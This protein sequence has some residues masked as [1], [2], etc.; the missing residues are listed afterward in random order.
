VDN[1]SDYF[2]INPI[3]LRDKVYAYKTKDDKYKIKFSGFKS[4][5]VTDKLYDDMYR[6]L[7]NEKDNI[8]MSSEYIRK[9]LNNFSIEHRVEQRTFIFNYDKRER[10]IKDGV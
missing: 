2:M 1:D 7:N 10:I 3:F 8:T 9:N 4:S 5:E 6:I